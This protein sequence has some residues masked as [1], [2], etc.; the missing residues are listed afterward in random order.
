[1]WSLPLPKPS[2]RRDSYMK[3]T[4]IFTQTEG[5]I[6]SDMGVVSVETGCDGVSPAGTTATVT[7]V[8]ALTKRSDSCDV[9]S[10]IR[11]YGLNT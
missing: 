3:S 7:V 1:M 11:Y 4:H 6:G 2:V 10:N 5:N 9:I 8:R